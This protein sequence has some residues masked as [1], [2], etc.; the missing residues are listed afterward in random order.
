MRVA[1]LISGTSVDGIDVAIVDV[2]DS[3]IDLIAHGTIP[4]PPG[5]R[6]VVLS[7]SNRVCHTADIA[8]LNFLIGELFAEAVEKVCAESNLPLASIELVGS[9]GQTIFHEGD[10]IQYGG[11]QIASTLQI[12][13]PAV[14]AEKLRKPVIADFRVADVAAGGKG[15]PLVPFFDYRVFRH[16]ERHRVALNI[17]GISN[18]TVIPAGCSPTGVIAFD[19]GPGN[20][21]M[22]ALCPPFDEDG[23]KARAG[24]INVALVEELLR[25]PYYHRAPPKTAGR[26]QYGP[27]FIA[28]TGIDLTTAVELTARTIAKAIADYPQIQEVIVSGG[29][30]HNSYLLERLQSHLGPARLLKASELGVNVDA[31]EAML[32]ALLAYENWSGRPAGMPSVTGARHAALLGKRCGS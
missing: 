8:R 11:R 19:T 16:A 1:G 28:R 24:A 2:D 17:G 29:G 6:T 32:F 18:I 23:R 25:D 27:E 5:L 26:E 9:H 13:E 12:G 15:A 21:V 3:R 10:P 14:I 30:S 7:V 20:M 22:D 31:K 4:Y